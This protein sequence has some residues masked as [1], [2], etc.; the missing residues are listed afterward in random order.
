MKVLRVLALGAALLVAGCA[1]YTAIDGAKTVSVGD[2]VSVT[3]QIAWAQV[4]NPG[5]NG[6]VWTADGVMLDSLMFFTGVAP[7]QPLIKVSGT[8]K[9]D[10]PRPYQKGMVADD[11]MDLLVSNFSKIGYQHVRTANLHPARFGSA[12]GF[13]FEF[14]FDTQEGLDMKGTAIFAQRGDK[15]DLILFYAPS[16]YYYGRYSDIVEKIFAS[17]QAA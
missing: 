5:L 7:G 15:L 13:R 4:N 12:D 8:S 3:P 17:I 14:T 11:V 1:A 6:T 16:E 9:D 2:N 10:L